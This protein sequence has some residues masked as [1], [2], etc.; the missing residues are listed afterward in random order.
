MNIKSIVI[1]SLFILLAVDFVKSQNFDEDAKGDYYFEQ[2]AFAKAIKYYESDYFENGNK[3]ALLKLATSHRLLHNYTEAE[4]YYRKILS[5]PSLRNNTHYFY[6]A[7]ML[8]SNGK[9]NQYLKWI[10]KYADVLAQDT[11][12]NNLVQSPTYFKELL[13]NKGLYKIKDAEFNTEFSDI[14]PTFYND[15]MISYSS[16]KHSFKL[17]GAK[18]GYSNDAFYDMYLINPKT[19]YEVPFDEFN[20]KYHD[21]AP[22]F[23]KDG[24]KVY[25]TRTDYYDH[26]LI[27]N[28][29]NESNLEIFEA[30]KIDGKWGKEK[31][32]SFDD[33][34]FNIELPS[35]TKDG[36]TIF[37]AS[38]IEGGY[39]KLDLYRVDKQGETWSKPV[40]L[41]PEINTAEN[42]CFPFIHSSGNTL[43]FSSDGLPGLGGLDVFEAMI[44][45]SGTFKV[46]NLGYPVNEMKDDFAF[47]INDDLTSGYFTSDRPGGKG[48]DDIYS[49]THLNMK[50]HHHR[51][52][53]TIRSA[54]DSSIISNARVRHYDNFKH[55]LDTLWTQ[56]DGA[57]DFDNEAIGKYIVI[58]QAEGYKKA[59]KRI[60]ININHEEQL[61][62]ADFYLKPI[63]PVVEEVELPEDSL[64]NVADQTSDEN[65]TKLNEEVTGGKQVSGN[66]LSSDS[67][68]MEPS[69]RDVKAVKIA[70]T[71]NPEILTSIK[72]VKIRR[73]DTVT[74]PIF[75]QFNSS[76][77]SR[78]S[79]ETL[80]KLAQYLSKNPQLSVQINSHADCR[81]GDQYNQVL[82]IKRAQSTALYLAGKGVY[83]GKMSLK[84]YGDTKPI[85]EC[86]C[87][88]ENFLECSEDDYLQNRRTEFKFI[89]EEDNVA[90]E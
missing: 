3:E 84:G 55:L 2:K 23:T 38:D 44:T 74:P 19:G 67:K 24:N 25:F 50:Y 72:G 83:L 40:N 4:K 81:G 62:T 9:Y 73:D 61:Y 20:T 42:E 82:T 89:Y 57:F 1:A 14:A 64:S 56:E 37:F 63:E 54:K 66:R 16:N 41:G 7:E 47:V 79:E 15:T 36:N 80:D 53:G 13:E 8:K 17:F 75:F 49:F 90:I 30:E 76:N 78:K 77:V 35:I 68:D 29:N 21:V 60:N 69:K 71:N 86:D 27:K 52:V 51:I 22:T 58:V 5:T 43:Y 11:V 48:R 31:L 85:N 39:G 65:Q 33:E 6:F 26:H 88:S 12:H 34:N 45:D 28:D 70:E 59:R 87:N 18:D 32:V 10:R 46:K